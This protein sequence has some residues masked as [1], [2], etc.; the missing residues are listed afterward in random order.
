MDAW[1]TG[2]VATTVGLGVAVDVGRDTGMEVGCGVG[3]LDAVA[4]GDGFG[5][6]VGNIGKGTGR[7]GIAVNVGDGVA[8]IVG[9]GVCVIVGLGITVGN[10]VAL[11]AGMSVAVGISAGVW[12]EAGGGTDIGTWAAGASMLT[13]TANTE[14]PGVSAR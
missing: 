13:P 1:T 12:A 9:T 7:V 10:A 4:V 6:F 5:A 14:N 11:G 3:V 2:P 8:V